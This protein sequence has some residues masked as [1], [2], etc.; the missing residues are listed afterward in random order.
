MCTFGERFSCSHFDLNP[1]ECMLSLEFSN[2]YFLHDLSYII[3]ELDYL[4]VSEKQQTDMQ[5]KRLNNGKAPKL[6]P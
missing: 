3:L 2:I 4:C 5:I 6:F 1:F